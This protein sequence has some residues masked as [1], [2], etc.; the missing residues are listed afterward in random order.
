[1]NDEVVY[2]VK[3][4]LSWLV[5]AMSAC[6][7]ILTKRRTGQLWSLWIVLCAAWAIL[8]L[9]NTLLVAGVE[10]GREQLITIW[11]SSYVLV[12]A[13]LALLFLK[14]ARL[15]RQKTRQP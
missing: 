3:C 6:G 4:G 8:A 11:L 9:P 12:M 13:S 15:M 14:V 2:A 5:V 10:M 7:L 1:M